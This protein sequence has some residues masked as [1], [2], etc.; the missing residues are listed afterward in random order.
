MTG[1]L[2]SEEGAIHLH[3]KRME[4]PRLQRLNR[5]VMLERIDLYH[6]PIPFFFSQA[7]TSE[8]SDEPPE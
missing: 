4:N 7:A 8:G 2:K 6:A 3:P 5:I 1:V